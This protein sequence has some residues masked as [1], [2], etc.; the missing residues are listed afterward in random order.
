MKA[1]SFEQLSIGATAVG[2]DLTT[3]RPENRPAGQ[4]VMGV[5]EGGNVRYRHDGGTPTSTV[6]HQLLAGEPFILEGEGDIVDLRF[7]RDAASA[8]DA[9]L[10]LTVFDKPRPA[11][12]VLQS[13]RFG[14]AVSNVTSSVGAT[15]A[16]IVDVDGTGD[17]GMGLLGP[18]DYVRLAV[19][20]VVVTETF[21]DNDDTQPVVS[22]GTTE[23]PEA[24]VPGAFF[25]DK[26]ADDELMIVV[27]V[28][29][30]DTMMVHG[31]PA[32]ATGA[33]AVQVRVLSMRSGGPIT[34]GGLVE[35]E[36]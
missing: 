27:I 15:E 34:F 9:K 1:I 13:G 5:L 10:A 25:S 28:D 2:L 33:G 3:I 31:T 18:A 19:I 11:G 36:L 4:M 32:G 24:F 20:S 12:G 6:G 14:A 7:V 29:A 8:T 26:Q 23:D 16:N 30:N 17:G 35:E 22:I 21:A